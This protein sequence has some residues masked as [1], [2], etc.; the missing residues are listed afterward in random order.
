MNFS[1][2]DREQDIVGHPP[3]IAPL[4]RH[5]YADEVRAATRRLRAGIVGDDVDLPVESIPEI[6]FVM[7]KFPDIWDKLTALALQIQSQT[8]QLPP[9]DRQMA[10][11]RTAWLMQAPYEWGQHVS[12]SKSVGIS[13]EEIERITQGSDAPGW[14]E[15][16][17]ALLCAAE[18]LRE[19]AMVSDA[20]WNLLAATLNEHQLFELLVLIG[21]FT[22]TAY[23]QNSLRLRLEKGNIGLTAR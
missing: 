3:R 16:E 5:Q 10:I 22:A 23:Y 13:S 15:H 17:K 2:P 11:L 6:M 8:G 4:D 9:R 19:N 12:V 20:T 18:E 14:T 7:A 21:Q 1:I